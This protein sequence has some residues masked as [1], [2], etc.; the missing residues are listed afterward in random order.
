MFFFTPGAVFHQIVWSV[1]SA[2]T[3]S[4]V[5]IALPQS[6]IDILRLQL[7]APSR[8]SLQSWAAH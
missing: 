1:T 3:L 7:Q 5:S 4:S 2:P 6:D 8:E